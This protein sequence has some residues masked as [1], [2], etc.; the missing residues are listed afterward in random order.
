M[1][2]A[3]LLILLL[4]CAAPIHRSAPADVVEALVTADPVRGPVIAVAQ[5]IAAAL[6]AA[7]VWKLR[8]FLGSPV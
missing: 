3:L 8:K 4:T 2:L 7:T 6:I 5:L 1:R